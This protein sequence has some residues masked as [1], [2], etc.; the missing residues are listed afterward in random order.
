MT[1]SK[2]PVTANVSYACD[3]HHDE[4]SM[5]KR[6]SKKAEKQEA[7]GFPRTEIIDVKGRSLV[8]G[9]N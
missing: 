3:G 8:V 6:L 5:L 4:P 1:V 7:A 9:L 2:D